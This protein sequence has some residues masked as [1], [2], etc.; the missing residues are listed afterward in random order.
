MKR[1]TFGVK[2]SGAIAG[3]GIAGCS[4]E[5]PVKPEESAARTFEEVLCEF[6][7]LLWDSVLEGAYDFHKDAEF[8]SESACRE[9]YENYR[10][11]SWYRVMKR[12]LRKGLDE[13]GDPT[14]FNHDDFRFFYKN[15]Y[16]CSRRAGVKAARN[17]AHN[18]RPKIILQDFTDAMDEV[19]TLMLALAKKSEKSPA[20]IVLAMCGPS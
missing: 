4:P 8:E 14:D 1:R 17:A 7:D 16:V 12:N 11:G 6:K 5:K 13:V 3:L 20:K 19:H 15:F 10:E 18:N 2:V 9:E